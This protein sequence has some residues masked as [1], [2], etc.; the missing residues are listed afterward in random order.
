MYLFKLLLIFSG[1]SF[2]LLILLISNALFIHSSNKISTNLH[3]ELISIQDSIDEDD[4]QIHKL[5]IQI[6]NGG[7]YNQGNLQ[8]NVNDLITVRNNKVDEFKKLYEEYFL[9]EKES[10]E[11]TPIVLL[12]L[13]NLKS[14]DSF[15]TKI[16]PSNKGD[17]VVLILSNTFFI[18]YVNGM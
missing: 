14:N 17:F 8:Q 5:T 4:K 1:I 18:L 12:I 13:S 3:T 16:Y 2:S 10:I 11:L 9:F 6:E 7:M 15:F